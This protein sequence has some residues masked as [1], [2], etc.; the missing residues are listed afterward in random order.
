MANESETVLE[1]GDEG[2]V[3][4]GNGNDE[5]NNNDSGDDN[6]KDG[7]G[8]NNGNKKPEE[9]PEAKRARLTRQ[10][11]QL[12]KKYP[13]AKDEK[14]SSKKSDDL[15]YGQKAYLVANGIKGDEMN[16]V[17]EFMANTGKS[18]DDALD[19]KYLQAEL[20]EFREA[21]ATAAAVPGN[22]KRSGQSGAST[23]EYWIAKGEL[24][25]ASDRE[26]RQKVVNARIKSESNTS[27]FTSNPVV[28]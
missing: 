19:N 1:P 7:Q 24:P 9:T 10:L 18:L 11:E 25:P 4:P 22:T 17:K 13:V 27:M 16:V 28:S 5:G 3:E 14:K 2:Y 23:V 6:N 15:D 26:L 21:K 8:D 12:D 20:K